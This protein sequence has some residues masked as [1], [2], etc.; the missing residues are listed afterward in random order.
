MKTALIASLAVVL[1][2]CSSTE[3]VTQTTDTVSYSIDDRRRDLSNATGK[4]QEHCKKQGNIAKLETTE[5]VGRNGRV[6]T[7]KCV[8]S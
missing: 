3:T 6:V 4:A 8:A 1:A 2:A 7:F 5:K